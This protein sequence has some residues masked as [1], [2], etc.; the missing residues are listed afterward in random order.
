MPIGDMMDAGN[1]HEQEKCFSGVQCNTCSLYSKL[2]QV[3]GLE[4]GQVSRK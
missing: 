3:T 1:M 4:R 2:S